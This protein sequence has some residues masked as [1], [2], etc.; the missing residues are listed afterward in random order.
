MLW[1]TPRVYLPSP[2][3]LQASLALSMCSALS[4]LP[5]HG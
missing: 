1:V 4:G 2:A 3:H 5:L